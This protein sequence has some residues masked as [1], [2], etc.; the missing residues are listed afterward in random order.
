VTST[1]PEAPLADAAARD[2][3]TREHGR[4]ISVIAPAGV[5]KTFGIV[6]RILHLARL[7]EADAVDRLTR[8]VVVTYSVRA[9]QEMQQRARAEIRRARLS[10]QVQ[11][12]FQRTFF[13]TIHSFC[14]RLLGRFGHYL[15]VP[16]AMT[17]PSSEDELWSRFLVHGLQLDIA[18]DAGLSE[19]FH[20]YTVQELYGL[21]KIVSPGPEIRPGPMTIPDVQ[22]L[23]DHGTQGLH[24]S[25]RKSVVKAQTALK[26]WQ[27]AWARGDRYHPLP[28]CPDIKAPDF[29]ALWRETFAPLQDWLREGAYA[30]GRQLANSYEAFRLAEGVMTYDD[31]VRLALRALDQPAVQ[32]EL[33]QDRLSI[34]LDEAQDTDLRQ[35]DVLL[36]VAGIRPEINQAQ[37][38]TFC[39]VG[40]FQQAIWAPRSDLA[41]YQAVHNEIS[42]DPHGLVSRLHVTFRC[43]RAIIDFVNRVF[44]RLLDAS[45]GQARFETLRARDSAGPGQVVRWPCPP[46][47][48]CSPE[49]KFTMEER[50]R[51]EAAFL[52]REIERL[53]PLGLGADRWRDVAV[54]CPRR[55]WLHQIERELKKLGVPVQMHSGTETFAESTPRTWLTALVWVAAHPEESFEIAGVLRDIFGVSDHDMAWHTGGDGDLLRLDRFQNRGDGPVHAALAILHHGCGS[56]ARLPL[57]EA[58]R[59]L[60]EQTCLRE[61]LASI[62]DEHPSLVDRE[63]DETLDLIDQRCAEGVTLDELARE[64]RDSLIQVS[65]ADEEVRDAVQLCTSHKAKGLEWQTVVVPFLFRFI[66]VKSPRYP[67][68]VIGPD[69]EELYRDVA[70]FKALAK[71]REV[72]REKQQLQRLL[73][74][75][76]TRPRHNLLLID[77]EALFQGQVHRGLATSAQLLQFDQGETRD[78]WKSLPENLTP[79]I[80]TQN[81]DPI[82]AEIVPPAD[83]LTAEEVAR[84]LRRANS[85]PRRVTPH[86]LARHAPAEAEPERGLEREEDEPVRVHPGILYGTWWHELMETI[87][88]SR[89]RD[90]WQ[91]R[92]DVAQTT[93]P[94]PE[95]SRRE[96]DLLLRS[97]LSRWLEGPDLL[98]HPE[99]PFLWPESDEQCLEGVIDLAVFS[100]SEES[101]QVIDWKTNRL[102]AEGGDAVAALY[103]PQVEAYTRALRTLA[104][105]EVRG[106]LY[107]TGSGE[108]L[109][110]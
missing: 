20:F 85:I 55:D 26:S 51:H 39:V 58:I 11:R 87:P 42:A 49:V 38:Q 41:V 62:H 94:Q 15:G 1:P 92:F 10:L 72:R 75:T 69:G 97:P 50:A 28:P 17:L 6:Q 71:E 32:R 88:W 76:C 18:A 108:W 21:G 81:V 102:P 36:R 19:L 65:P 77:D 23:I 13:G 82:P 46:L 8:L 105:G 91:Q 52:A 79:K 9:A 67:R 101:W 89:P 61:R 100:P 5:G 70:S 16:A 34:L 73:Y 107:L 66:D 80:P 53:R 109:R 33:K 74:V 90:A 43:D 64:L 54:L 60:A 93:S 35:F 31:Q 30:F 68:L 7:P 37:N 84:A 95:R 25:T 40:D 47:V 3:F 48:S 99:L 83:P 44:D 12:A 98:I 86:A 110:L 106:S 96:W 78:L 27:E 24:P 2:L 63:L 45:Q 104:P 103:R 4:N 29:V 57:H 56:F 14:V 22:R 59:H